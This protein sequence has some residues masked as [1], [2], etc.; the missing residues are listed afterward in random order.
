LALIGVDVTDRENSQLAAIDLDDRPQRQLIFC[1]LCIIRHLS[2][3]FLPTCAALVCPWGGA[4]GFFYSAGASG[5]SIR[6]SARRCSRNT[7]RAFSCIASRKK[8]LCDSPSARAAATQCLTSLSRNRR[9]ERS[10]YGVGVFMHRKIRYT[11]TG[12]NFSEHGFDMLVFVEKND[13]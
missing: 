8:A 10:R 11:R 13:A 3:F 6:N 2:F 9:E 7:R 1:L 5:F 4:V 12:D